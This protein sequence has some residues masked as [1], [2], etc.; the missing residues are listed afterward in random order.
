MSCLVANLEPCE[1]PAAPRMDSQQQQQ[2]KTGRA[3][4]RRSRRQ[5]TGSLVDSSV[6]ASSLCTS[7]DSDF[8]YN[9]E[10]RVGDGGESGSDG[11][12]SDASGSNRTSQGAEARAQARAASPSPSQESS[13]SDSEIIL[14]VASPPPPNS[15]ILNIQRRATTST[16]AAAAVFPT[17]PQTTP[18]ITPPRKRVSVRGARRAPSGAS[19]FSPSTQS[20]TSSS[21]SSSS[22][23][24]VPSPPPPPRRVSTRSR[25]AAPLI[26][27]SS[28]V[29]RPSTQRTRGAV[30]SQRLDST[31]RAAAGSRPLPPPPQPPPPYGSNPRSTPI[32]TSQ[33]TKA[34]DGLKETFTELEEIADALKPTLGNLLS[35]IV[36][37]QREFERALGPL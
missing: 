14:V 21:S 1:L 31:R 35:G 17:S 32:P 20:F 33:V 15:S 2:S 9:P 16:A 27:P 4:L 18:R 23:A 7:L 37:R 22:S 24:A 8:T 5:Y 36:A 12:G 10:R 34:R 6:D 29:R 25:P 19:S 26:P 13:S 3:T 30:Q 28:P 11:V